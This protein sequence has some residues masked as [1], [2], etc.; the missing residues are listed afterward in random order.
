M[1]PCGFVYFACDSLCYAVDIMKALYEEI[2]VGICA[3]CIFLPFS[4]FLK[5][6]ILHDSKVL[7][8]VSMEGWAN[9]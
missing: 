4:S 6:M 9:I 8:A 1:S 2:R 5:R 7:A 3:G